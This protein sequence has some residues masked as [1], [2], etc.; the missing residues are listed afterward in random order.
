MYSLLKT[1]S[2]SNF[3]NSIV[4]VHG[5]GGH[6]ID[7]WTYTSP[8]LSAGGLRRTLGIP[9]KQPEERDNDGDGSIF[10]PAELLPQS[11]KNARILTYGYDSDPVHF[12]NSVNR[13]NIYQHATNLLQNLSDERM[14]DVC[15]LPY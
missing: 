14:E 13:S 15:F 4:L 1:S 5:L 10:W 3:R 7:T 8:K 9:K 6:P 2:H 11:I 12:L